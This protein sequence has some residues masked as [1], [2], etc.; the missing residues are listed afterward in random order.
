MNVISHDLSLLSFLDISADRWDKIMKQCEDIDAERF[1]E[2]GLLYSEELW[3]RGHFSLELP[4]KFEFSQ[5]VIDS[6]SNLLGF[7]I[8]AKR[9]DTVHHTHRVA[10][11]GGAS[12]G[13]DVR[14]GLILGKES[15]KTAQEAGCT[16]AVLTVNS[17]NQRAI[18]FYRTLG[19]QIIT[20]KDLRIWADMWGYAENGV[21]EDSIVI[22]DDY[23]LAFLKSG[24]LSVITL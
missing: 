7:W 23:H 21:A 14:I 6:A 22:T 3:L 10:T 11:R 13:H 19:Y 9:E 4:G 2:L 15:L 16:Q 18:N 1:N 17:R 8:A 5:V 20:G 12:A 24:N